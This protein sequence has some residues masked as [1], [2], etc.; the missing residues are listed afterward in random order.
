MNLW[1]YAGYGSVLAI[2]LIL[3]LLSRNEPVAGKEQLSEG[4]AL[5]GYAVP[6]QKMAQYLQR[7]LRLK[8]KPFESAVQADLVLLDPSRG[9]RQREQSYYLEKGRN[10]LLFLFLADLAALLVLLSQ[11]QSGV[12]VDGRSVVRNGYGKTA[13]EV[14]AQ[15]VPDEEGPAGEEAL[16]E[17]GTYSFMVS[18]RSYTRK[19]CDAFAE[20]VFLQLPELIRGDNRDL[21]AVSED[22][23]LPSQVSGYPFRIT[24]RSSDYQLVD[25]AGTVT[26]QL[27]EGESRQLTLT[28]VLKYGDYRYEKEYAV[29]LLPPRRTKEERIRSDI[30]ELLA[31]IDEETREDEIYALPDSINGR[32]V[33]WEEQIH[34]NSVLAFLLIAGAGVLMYRYSDKELH[35]K[36]EKRNREMVVD[37]P[38]LVSKFV[39]FLGA[40]M[41]VR[42]VFFKLGNDYQQQ[43]R[44]GGEKRFVYEELL[45][46]CHE[47][48]SGISESAAYAHFGA[49]CRSRQYTKFC[50]LLTQ[51]MKKGNAALLI[52]LQDEAEYAMEERKNTARQLGEEAGT[53]LLAPM[54][55]ML[56]ITMVMILIPAFS[57]FSF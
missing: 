30:D 48:E 34:D 10:L 24:W 12:L 23:I 13:V 54:L 18:P 37:Y 33:H 42:N 36:V 8:Q 55:I 16:E 14:T 17:F 25:A 19:Q 43:R 39:L 45:L 52:A 11:K 20:E 44:K 3:M 35:R 47:L 49:R 22:L 27:A 57:S 41:S 40:G 9:V 56:V 53:K 26:S 31:R 51:N 15:A 29:T 7:K 38:T 46:V 50:S 1:L 4:K 6:F 2:L 28:A 32:A 5:P 21:T